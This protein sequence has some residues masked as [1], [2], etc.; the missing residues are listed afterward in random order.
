MAELHTL[1]R[2][3]AKAVFELAQESGQ[4]PAWSAQLAVIAKTIADP[5]VAA[6]VGHPAVSRGELAGALTGALGKQLTPEG[7]ALLH[8]LADNNRLQ[9]AGEVALQ[10]EQRRA[11][12][13]ARADVQIVTAVP[14]KAPQQKALAAAVGKRL[15]REVI[16]DWKTDESLLAGAVVRAGDLV[17][18][19]S[20]RGELERMK[21][22]LSRA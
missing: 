3:Y 17:I 21:S 20:V 22:A 13:E 10:F 19:G 12:A 9:A 4:L 7:G 6:L 14:V 11:E 2:P 1:A 16:I 15:A 5:Q 18:D 8:L